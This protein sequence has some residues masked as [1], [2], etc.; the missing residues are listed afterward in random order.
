M[1]LALLPLPLLFSWLSL[2]LAAHWTLIHFRHQPTD[3][4]PPPAAAA[5]LTKPLATTE[6]KLPSLNQTNYH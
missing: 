3:Q 2:S 5:S 4:P 1:V 6:N